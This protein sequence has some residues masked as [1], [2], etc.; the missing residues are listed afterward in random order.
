MSHHYA[1]PN[2]GFPHGDA[3]LNLTDLYAF[4]KPGS[5]RKSILII[6]VHPSSTF[7][8]QTPT[9]PVPFA[10]Q[11]L[12]ELKIDTNGDAVA[13]VA[14]RIQ[15]SPFANGAQTAT[16][17]HV[18]GAQAAGIGDDGRSYRRGCA[19]LAG[20]RGAGYGRWR[21]SLLR[22]LAQRSLLLRSAGRRE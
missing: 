21:L 10:P 4:P 14:Y 5:D 17:R 16:L 15:F 22:R 11:A 20:S 7:D 19:G 9:T 12:Y 6:D 1:G 8:P 13:D 18:E 3:R 2:F